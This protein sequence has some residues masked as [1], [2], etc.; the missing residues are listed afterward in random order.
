MLTDSWHSFCAEIGPVTELWANT[1]VPHLARDVTDG[2]TFI[3]TSCCRP[4]PQRNQC[5][6]ELPDLFFC[7]PVY[8]LPTSR[9][10]MTKLE[11]GSRNPPRHKTPYVAIY[12]RCSFNPMSVQ[13]VSAWLK[14]NFRLL[15]RDCIMEWPS[16]SS[17]CIS[18]VLAP[19]TPS[20]SSDI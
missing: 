8:C 16:Y 7:C 2:N 11:I 1:F 13:G 20:R 5:E 15:C 10:K 19:G 6:D 9:F 3:I 4:N 18:S 12:H 14:S 17:V